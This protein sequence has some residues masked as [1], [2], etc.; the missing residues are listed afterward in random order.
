M[1]LCNKMKPILGLASISLQSCLF[2]QKMYSCQT[3]DFF[4][5]GAGA[6]AWAAPP[7]RGVGGQGG[8]GVP[9]PC[10][11]MSRRDGTQA[12]TDSG[13]PLTAGGPL[14]LPHLP[15]GERGIETSLLIQVV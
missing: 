9:H 8:V 7:P 3:K 5:L 13:P 12:G 14:D 11:G 6:A 1:W 4:G 15:C 2:G 10:G